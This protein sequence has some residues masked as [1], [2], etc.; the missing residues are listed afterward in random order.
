MPSATA[1]FFV[2]LVAP[3][4]SLAYTTRVGSASRARRS[5]SGAIIL[6]GP[7]LRGRGRTTT[8][9]G[10]GVL[11]TQRLTRPDH[12]REKAHSST[13]RPPV[14]SSAAR[15]GK[16]DLQW[17]ACWP[18]HDARTLARPGQEQKPNEQHGARVGAVGKGCVTFAHSPPLPLTTR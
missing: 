3:Q 15:V 13:L 5:S 12:A 18:A 1:N 10:Q 9:R 17:R 11:R 2:S 14:C 7:H 16:R 4:F 8:M 6:Q